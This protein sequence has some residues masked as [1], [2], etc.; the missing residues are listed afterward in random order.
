MRVEND[1]VEEVNDTDAEDGSDIS[2]DESC[3][4]NSFVES[5]DN[6]CGSAEYHDDEDSEDEENEDELED[7]GVVSE[8][9]G[10]EGDSVE[11]K[12][13]SKFFDVPPA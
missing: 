4:G 9:D 6:E 3:E 7:D 2:C 8:E 12:V 11:S 1:E 5:D 13:G 10:L